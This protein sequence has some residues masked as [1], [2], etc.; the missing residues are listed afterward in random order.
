[1][2]SEISQVVPAMCKKTTAAKTL[3][4]KCFMGLT[5]NRRRFSSNSEW[6][7][8]SLSAVLPRQA[9]SEWRGLV[10]S[11]HACKSS[12]W[13]RRGAQGAPEPYEYPAH[14][15]INELQNCA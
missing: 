1:M 11:E 4:E 13:K 9:G 6:K 2:A 8:A 3:N 10:C 15:P 14:F 7:A 5:R 12:S